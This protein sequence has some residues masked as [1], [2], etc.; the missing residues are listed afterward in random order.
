MNTFGQ[1]VLQ[2]W[3]LLEDMFPPLD[4]TAYDDRLNGA[5][6]WERVADVDLVAFAF[7][8]LLKKVR[9][10][11]SSHNLALVNMILSKS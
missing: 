11:H 3:N 8:F 9:T 10:L 1:L 2:H 6:L 4:K 7:S 5:N